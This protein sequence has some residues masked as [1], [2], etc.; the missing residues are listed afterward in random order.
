MPTL[1]KNQRL[2]L[3][4]CHAHGSLYC[5]HGDQSSNR[6]R[7]CRRWSS[8]RGTRK[9][10]DNTVA[11]LEIAGLVEI[12]TTKDGRRARITPRGLAVLAAQCVAELP[13]AA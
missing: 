11:A 1:N 2:A 7:G 9:H 3:A 8:G 6:L 13:R 10:H 5:R 12:S 4:V